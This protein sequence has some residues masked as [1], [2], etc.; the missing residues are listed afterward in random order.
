MNGNDNDEMGSSDTLQRSNDFGQQH[1]GSINNLNSSS[2]EPYNNNSSFPN[3]QRFDQTLI[4]QQIMFFFPVG[5]L[6]VIIFNL[7]LHLNIMIG[8]IMKMIN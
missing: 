4:I 6:L 5:I 2:I 3:T 7:I 1:Y 8:L